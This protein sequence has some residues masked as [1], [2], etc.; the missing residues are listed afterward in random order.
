MGSN[1]A[2]G[3]GGRANASHVFPLVW[4]YSD[5]GQKGC[6]GAGG[7]KQLVANIVS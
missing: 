3:G 4:V 1:T 5:P 2:R 7:E 6:S